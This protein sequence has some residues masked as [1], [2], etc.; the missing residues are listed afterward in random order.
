MVS[1][2]GKRKSYVGISNRES[3]SESDDGNVTGYSTFTRNCTFP[4]LFE[5][6]GYS[7]EKGVIANRFLVVASDSDSKAEEI[8]D[9]KE[10]FKSLYENWKKTSLENVLLIK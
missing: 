9:L 8:T 3:E 2:K 7:S 4:T 5:A 1:Q 10:E 6:E